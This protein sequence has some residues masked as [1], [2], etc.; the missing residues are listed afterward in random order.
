MQRTR[1]LPSSVIGNHL[2][3]RRFS[4][5]KFLVC[6]SVFSATALGAASGQAAERVLKLYNTHTKEHLTVV[7]K[8]NGRYSQAGLKKLNYFLRDWRRNQPIKM[9]PQLFDIVWTAYKEVGATKPIHV[10]SGFRSPATNNMLRRRGRGVAKNSRHTLGHAMDFF[11]PGVKLSKLRAAG[12]RLEAGGVGYYPRSG[13]P[14]VHFDTGTV[15]HWPRMSRRELVKVFPRGKT[16]HVPTDGK[17]LRGY[18]VAMA[19]YQKR[20]RS[21]TLVPDRRGRSFAIA[22]KVNDDPALQAETLVAS[23]EQAPIPVLLPPR[24]R[25]QR[26]NLLADQKPVTAGATPGPTT[27]LASAQQLLGINQKQPAPAETQVAALPSPEQ[28]R[29]AADNNPALKAA[30]ARA[31]DRMIRPQAAPPRPA[32][33]ANETEVPRLNPR[34]DRTI[35]LPKTASLLAYAPTVPRIKPEEALRPLL[36]QTARRPARP[37]LVKQATVLAGRPVSQGQPVPARNPR[38]LMTS[39]KLAEQLAKTLLVQQLAELQ[40]RRHDPSSKVTP[41]RVTASVLDRWSAAN[42]I[43]HRTAAKLTRPSS[44][45]WSGTISITLHRDTAR[46]GRAYITALSPDRFVEPGNLRGSG[47]LAFIRQR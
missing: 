43:H 20:K 1:Q 14:F 22:G 29:A 46:F 10:V 36:S 16:I 30:L 42:S 39:I 3:A 21:K 26:T 45:A 11:I 13:S 15:R 40:T 27:L 5:L 25:P 41:I 31:A 32:Q 9:D 35:Q 23:A 47:Q 2:F 6:I 4:L 33:V 17:P 37:E 44:A 12:L 24:R 28:L 38:R 19:D 18:K 34:N 7:Y 8:K